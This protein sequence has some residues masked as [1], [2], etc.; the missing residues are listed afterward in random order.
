M[1]GPRIQLLTFTGCPLA[2]AAKTELEAA[3]NRLGLNDYE[4]IDLNAHNTPDAL[5]GWGSPTILI[6][7]VDVTG[8]PKGDQLSCRVYATPEKVPDRAAIAAAI[9]NR[10]RTAIY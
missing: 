7:G 5:R 9:G 6:D 2:S 1:P 3:L 8:Q 10:G 4:E